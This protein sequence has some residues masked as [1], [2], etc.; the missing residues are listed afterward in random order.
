MSAQGRLVVRRGIARTSARVFQKRSRPAVAQKL[1]NLGAI[2]GQIGLA[3]GGVLRQW[4]T[5][6]NAQRDRSRIDAAML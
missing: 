5:I 2:S 6:A 4:I 3:L 1:C